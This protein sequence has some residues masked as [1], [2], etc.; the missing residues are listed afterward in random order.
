MAKKRGRKKATPG[1]EHYTRLG[2]IEPIDYIKSLG[3]IEPHCVANVIK[4]VSRYKVKGGLLDLQ[5]ARQYID[6]L[7]EEVSKNE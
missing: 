7:I 5:K 4:Y 3:L 6:W 2:I 1:G